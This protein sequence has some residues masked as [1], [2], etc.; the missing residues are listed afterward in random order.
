[1]P[2]EPAFGTARHVFWSSHPTG[3]ML[4]AMLNGLVEHG[5]LE[6][7]D[8]AGVQYRWRASFQG[9]WE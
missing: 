5:V 9:S 3:E 8:E 6:T 7:R 4:Y 2:D 1:M